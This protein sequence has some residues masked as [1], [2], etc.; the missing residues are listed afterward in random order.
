[1]QCHLTYYLTWEITNKNMELTADS[2][3]HIIEL[4]KVE[5]IQS[6]IY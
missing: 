3:I 1:M 4:N 6:I 5:Y 2:V